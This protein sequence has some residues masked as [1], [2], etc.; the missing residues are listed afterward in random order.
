M[1]KFSDIR[2]PAMTHSPPADHYLNPLEYV[3]KRLEAEAGIGLQNQQG[4]HSTQYHEPAHH[5]AFSAHERRINRM[6]H[7]S[8]CFPDGKL[9]LRGKLSGLIQ[10]M[11]KDTFRT[12]L[13][14]HGNIL[15]VLY[16]NFNTS[17]C[18]TCDLVPRPNRALHSQAPDGF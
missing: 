4:V 10:T 2:F 13:R 6:M 8:E 18:T 5:N 11:S 14:H 3:E 12:Y 17:T 7:I 9:S 16:I 15:T 1:K